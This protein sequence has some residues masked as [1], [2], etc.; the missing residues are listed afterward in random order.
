MA[1]FL[2]AARERVVIYDGAFGT[3]IQERHLTADDF[4]GEAFEGCNEF[5]VITRPDVIA[6]L[7]ASY[8]DVGV[9]VLETCTFGG[10]GI[11]LGEYGLADRTHEINLAAA[12]LAREVADGYATPDRP[13]WVAGSMGP[14]TKFPSLG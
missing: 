5:L 11:T 3:G 4:G 9:D 13:R 1:S 7:H 6:E 8:C 2:Q 10:L 12:R 14:G